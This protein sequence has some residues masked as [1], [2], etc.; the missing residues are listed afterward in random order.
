MNDKGITPTMMSL[1]G[2][3]PPVFSPPEIH[4]QVNE[5]LES[6]AAAANK[7]HVKM[8]KIKLGSTNDD[9]FPAAT[10]LPLM[11]SKVTNYPTVT[12]RKYAAPNTS[13]ELIPKSILDRA[14]HKKQDA[15]RFQKRMMKNDPRGLVTGRSP[16]YQSVDDRL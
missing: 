1:E 15:Y 10:G 9:L 3:R 14:I 4:V 8:P 2:S 6:S 12:N 11:G 13:Q 5:R 7:R 16:V